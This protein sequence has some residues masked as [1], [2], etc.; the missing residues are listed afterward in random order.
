MVN[1]TTRI[2]DTVIGV[3]TTVTLVGVDG[4]DELLRFTIVPPG[5]GNPAE[6]KVSVE[7]P[8]GRA[9]VGR[10]RGDEVTVVSPGASRRYRIACVQR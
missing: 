3:G 6:R 4:E 7:A 9:V 2:L 10:R 8:L 5:D 1:D